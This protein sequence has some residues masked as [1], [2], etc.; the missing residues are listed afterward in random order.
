MILVLFAVV[1]FAFLIIGSVAFLACVL[2]PPTRRY[3]L[4]TALWFAVWGPCS[5]ALIVLAVLGLASGSLLMKAGN[6]QWTEAP[7]LLAALGWGY[8]IVGALITTVA[9]TCAAWLHQVLMHRLTF[10]LFRLYAMAVSAGIGSVL[11]WFLGWWMMAKG[12][13]YIGLWWWIPAMLILTAG[14]GTAAYKGARA[15]R[16]KAPTRF[17]WISPEEFVGSDIS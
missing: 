12:T 10:A 7:K 15:L 6:M 8:V 11:G 17:T 13:G 4:S 3:A 14:S 16:G 5:V 9:A 2:L 1:V